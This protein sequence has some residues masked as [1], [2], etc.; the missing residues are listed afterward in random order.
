VRCPLELDVDRL[1]GFAD[2]SGTNRR[3]QLLGTLCRRIELAPEFRRLEG[4]G[5][6]PRGYA[7]LGGA[8]RMQRIFR[9]ACSFV[10]SARRKCRLASLEGDIA[11]EKPVHQIGRQP[12]RRIGA[13]V[14]PIERGQHRRETRLSQCPQ[15][16][17]SERK[18]EREGSRRVTS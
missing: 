16:Y 13:R 17:G 5:G 12:V 10:I 15:R 14:G 1:S 8:A 11:N 9:F 4:N 3:Y 2:R 7:D 6:L 18:C